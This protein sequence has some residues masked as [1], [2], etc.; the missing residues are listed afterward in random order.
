[1]SRKESFFFLKKK[2]LNFIRGKMAAC[3]INSTET[4]D[5]TKKRR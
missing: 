5:Y 2:E 1:M 3:S 4:K